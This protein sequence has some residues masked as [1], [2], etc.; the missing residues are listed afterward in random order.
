MIF[1]AVLVERVAT[2][3]AVVV[4]VGEQIVYVVVGAEAPFFARAW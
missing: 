2:V 4:V 1:P 3:E